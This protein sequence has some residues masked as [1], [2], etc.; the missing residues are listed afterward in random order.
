M[1]II[2]PSKEEISEFPIH[3]DNL[4]VPQDAYKTILTKEDVAKE[5]IKCL[6]CEEGYLVPDTARSREA[7]VKQRALR[8]N[9]FNFKSFDEITIYYCSDCNSQ[10]D[11]REL[12]SQTAKLIKK[13]PDLRGIAKACKP[14]VGQGWAAK[15]GFKVQTCPINKNPCYEELWKVCPHIGNDEHYDLV[16]APGIPHVGEK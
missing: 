16:N 1:A 9:A 7:N 12:A 6:N 15:K 8:Y 10:H 14:N 3:S 11:A 5:K 13:S 2:I 4:I